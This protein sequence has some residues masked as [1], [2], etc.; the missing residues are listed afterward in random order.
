MT[1]HMI[2]LSKSGIFIS[3]TKKI[4]KIVFLSSAIIFIFLSIYKPPLPRSEDVVSQIK[5]GDP[6]QTDLSESQKGKEIVARM[7]KYE[8][9]V[10]PLFNYE[11]NGLVV[12]DYNS[13]NWLDIRHENDPGNIKDIC[14]VWGENINNGSYQKVKFSSGEFTCFYRWSRPLEKEFSGHLLSNNHLIPQNGE[15][16]EKIRNSKIGDQVKIKGVLADYSVYVDGNEIF[17]RKTST[18]RDDVRNGAC[19]IIYVVD[20]EVIRQNP[21]NFKNFTKTFGRISLSSGLLG[22]LLFLFV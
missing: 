3:L 9:R 19:E 1:L 22:I 2:S 6:V 10:K 14:V 11:I 4:V 18:S 21:L 20:F 8:Y 15:V 13:E 5:N 16:A 7:G 17:T 12:T